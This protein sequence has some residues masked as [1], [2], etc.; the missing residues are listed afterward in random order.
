MRLEYEISV[1]PT[2]CCPL[3]CNPVTR[4]RGG[5]QAW[6]STERH[7]HLSHPRMHGCLYLGSASIPHQASI[8]ARI[9]VTPAAIPRYYLQNSYRLHSFATANR[10]F[11][12][13][14]LHFPPE[15]RSSI[16]VSPGTFRG[17]L[18]YKGTPYS[19]SDG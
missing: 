13:T 8:A 7:H 1:A 2:E 5:H 10:L 6:G 15:K 9:S 11:A 4:S 12:S 18:W 19:M 3:R 17:Y 14:P 16:R